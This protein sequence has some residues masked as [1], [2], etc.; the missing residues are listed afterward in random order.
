MTSRDLKPYQLA[1]RQAQLRVLLRHYAKLVAR[2]QSLGLTPADPLFRRVLDTHHALLAEHTEVHYLT[3][4][5]DS[6]GH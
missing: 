6:T 5:R 1:R 2:L 3:C 4:P